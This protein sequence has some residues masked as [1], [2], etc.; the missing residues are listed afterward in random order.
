MSKPPFLNTSP[1]VFPACNDGP[2]R[3]G[4]G[5]CPSPEACMVPEAEPSRT[6]TILDTLRALFRATFSRAAR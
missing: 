6:P 2:C 3:Q 5:I 4:R 1:I